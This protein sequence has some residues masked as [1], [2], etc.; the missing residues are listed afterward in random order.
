MSKKNPYFESQ[1]EV[2]SDVSDISEEDV[3]DITVFCDKIL[4]CLTNISDRICRLESALLTVDAAHTGTGIKGRVRCLPCGVDLNT[5]T[6]EK[7]RGG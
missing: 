2:D 6:E 7:P 4:A 3:V 5:S 1:A